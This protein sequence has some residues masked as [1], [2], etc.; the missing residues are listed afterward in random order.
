MTNRSETLNEL[1]AALS[2]AQGSFPIIKKTSKGYNYNY[3]DLSEIMTSI[4]PILIE[5]GLALVH[6]SSASH[7]T[8]TLFHTSGQWMSTEFQLIINEKANGNATQARGS[9]I[10]YAKRY[11]ITSLLNLSADEDDDAASCSS[12]GAS[13]Q[14]RDY[15]PPYKQAQ[16]DRAIIGAEKKALYQAVKTLGDNEFIDK[17]CQRLG[18]SNIF[19]I[20]YENY[21]AVMSAINAKIKT[22]AGATS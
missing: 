18:I 10:T 19:D 17:M 7:L 21:N 13:D 20:Q 5:N 15:K 6:Q 1:I 14:G 22:L 12:N 11:N 3:A 8:T 4:Q 2:K 9:A 16:E